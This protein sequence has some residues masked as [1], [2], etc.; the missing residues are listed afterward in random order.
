MSSNQAHL[1]LAACSR[2]DVVWYLSN[3]NA[4]VGKVD[5]FLE[6]LPAGIC[7]A[8]LQ[9]CKEESKGAWCFTGQMILAKL[10]E[11]IMPACW[12]EGDFNCMHVLK[13]PQMI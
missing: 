5:C 6:A 10:L 9:E 3:G 7:F 2:G 4:M 8:V 11:V 1:K 13:P 12:A